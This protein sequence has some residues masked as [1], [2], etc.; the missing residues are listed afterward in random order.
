MFPDYIYAPN[1]KKYKIF[2]YLEPEEDKSPFI[3]F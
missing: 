3:V 2:D 1:G